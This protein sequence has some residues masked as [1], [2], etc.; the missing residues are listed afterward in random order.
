ME[1]PLGGIQIRRAAACAIFRVLSSWRHGPQWC[2]FLF[3]QECG[4]PCK[5]FVRKPLCA[6]DRI[7][8]LTFAALLF[9]FF[10]LFFFSF[11]SNFSPLGGIEFF[12]A[13]GDG[14]KAGDC[15]EVLLMA[16]WWGSEGAEPP[17]CCGFRVGCGGMWCACGKGFLCKW[18]CDQITSSQRPLSV[19]KKARPMGARLAHARKSKA[20]PLLLWRPHLG[21]G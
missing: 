4:G 1:I 10:F 6:P 11:F 2:V 20:N 21:R 14:R 18:W 8:Q 16:W 19:G 15:C 9:F 3:F 7:P 17:L 13:N 5:C 12:C